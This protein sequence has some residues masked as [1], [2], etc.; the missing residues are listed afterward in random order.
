MSA[1]ETLKAARA[2]GI[3]LALDGDD[4]VLEAASS[5]PAAVLNALSRHKAE[6]VVL[7]R[8]AE[9]GWSAEDWQVFFDERQRHPGKIAPRAAGTDRRQLKKLFYRD[10]TSR[11]KKAPPWHCS[12]G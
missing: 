3:E 1:V 5:P 12:N 9:D 7:L 10:P 6:I 4:L 11:T 8:P 2:T